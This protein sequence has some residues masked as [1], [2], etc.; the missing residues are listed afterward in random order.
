MTWFCAMRRAFISP[1]GLI[2]LDE[3][4]VCAGVDAVRWFTGYDQGA[5]DVWEGWRR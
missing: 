1:T 2:A 3:Q 5:T 4:T